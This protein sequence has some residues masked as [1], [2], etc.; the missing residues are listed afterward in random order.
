MNT[1]LFGRRISNYTKEDKERGACDVMTF[2][3]RDNKP[4]AGAIEMNQHLT[5]LQ[6]VVDRNKRVMYYEQRFTSKHTLDSNIKTHDRKNYGRVFDGIS[7]YIFSSF[8]HRVKINSKGQCVPLS[9]LRAVFF[10]VNCMA[11]SSSPFLA[12]R[13]SRYPVR[14]EY[15]FAA[16]EKA[17]NPGGIGK[18]DRSV[19]QLSCSNDFSSLNVIEKQVQKGYDS[20]ICPT[21][22]VLDT[23]MNTCCS[24]TEREYRRTP[25][26]QIFSK[27]K[28]FNP[29]QQIQSTVCDKIK[30]YEKN[31]R[32]FRNFDQ[33]CIQSH[34]EFKFW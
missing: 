20:G 15:F 8:I 17:Y 10:G 16:D 31:P 5:D 3:T 13:V 2:R 6:P 4:M 7:S 25:A 18:F 9:F 30:R 28:L 34:P 22:D 11:T 32:R 29:Q 21:S 33:D 12:T 1:P 24:L 19:P 26:C 27:Y 23:Y 14:L